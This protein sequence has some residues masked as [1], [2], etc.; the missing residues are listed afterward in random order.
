MYRNLKQYKCKEYGLIILGWKVGSLPKGKQ[1]SDVL[2]VSP[3]SG[4]KNVFWLILG[5]K[6]GSS[7]LG[8]HVLSVSPLLGAKK[9][10]YST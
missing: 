6:V 10:W 4:S 7:S 1:K 8:R 5:W 3:S 2:S 9:F